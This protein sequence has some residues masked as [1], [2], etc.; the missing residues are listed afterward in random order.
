MYIYPHIYK[1][2]VLK[3]CIAIEGNDALNTTPGADPAALTPLIFTRQQWGCRAAPL[4]ARQ[5]RV[6]GGLTFE[7]GAAGRTE[8]V[9]GE[10]EVVS[11][12]EP[13][14]RW[15]RSWNN[16]RYAITVHMPPRSPK[17]ILHWF[18]RNAFFFLLECLFSA[19][20]LSKTEEN[21]GFSAIWNVLFWKPGSSHSLQ[22]CFN[23]HQIIN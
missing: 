18:I 15:N 8:G 23:K 13:A 17:T 16:L 3:R 6:P 1:I 14:S 21:L 22:N 12:T 2:H 11:N 10:K 19:L 20:V 4:S 7:I 9:S 5:L